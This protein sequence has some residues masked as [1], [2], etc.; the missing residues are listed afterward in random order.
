VAFALFWSF[1]CIFP[2]LLSDYPFVMCCYVY[3][4][5]FIVDRQVNISI[6]KYGREEVIVYEMK[7]MSVLY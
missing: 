2:L 3:E 4:L 7:V 1:N 5:M 6:A